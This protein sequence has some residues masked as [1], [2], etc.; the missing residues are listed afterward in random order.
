MNVDLINQHIDNATIS[1]GEVQQA[2]YI[3]HNSPWKKGFWMKNTWT[4]RQS[5]THRALK[6]KKKKSCNV[7]RKIIWTVFSY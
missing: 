7:D 1:K 4:V 2:V 5:K 6:N 3:Q